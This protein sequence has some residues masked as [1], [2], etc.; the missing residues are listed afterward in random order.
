MRELEVARTDRA[1]AVR[2]LLDL[3]QAP[4]DAIVRQG[5]IVW[6]AKDYRRAYLR[7]EALGGLTAHQREGGE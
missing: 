5:E 4:S 6:A 3:L 2:R 1:E 7:Y